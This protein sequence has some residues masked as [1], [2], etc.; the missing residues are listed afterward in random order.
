LSDRRSGSI[1]TV[2]FGNVT[3]RGVLIDLVDGVYRLV[4]RAETRSTSGMPLNDARIAVRR[5]AEEITQVTGRTLLSSDGTVISPERADRNGVDIFITTASTGRT[6]RTLMVGLVPEVSLSSARRAASGTYIEVVDTLSLEDQRSDEDR[7]NAIIRSQADLIFIAGGMEGGAQEPVLKVAQIVTLALRLMQRKP[8]VLYAGNSQ[9]SARI[10]ELFDGVA[11]LFFASNVRPALDLEEL[12]SAQVQLALAFNEQQTKRGGFG[13]LSRMSNLGV[14]PT[15]QSYNVVADYLGRSLGG[16][17]VAVDVGSAVSILATAVNG[18][19]NTS[20]RTDIGLGHSADTALQVVGESAIERWLPF[21]AKPNQIKN[22]V[23]N[24]TLQP[25]SVPETVTALFLEYGLLRAS[26][27]EMLRQAQVGWSKASNPNET[28][29]PPTALVIGAGAAFTRSGNPGL[30]ALLLLDSIQPTGVTQ[31]QLDPYGLIAGLGALA[32]IS[33]EAVVQ[34]LD[35]GSLER[36]GTAI[37]ISGQPRPG[38]SAMRIKMI[39]SDGEVVRQFVQG[40]QIWVYPLA[41]GKT[42]TVEVSAGRGLNIGGKRSV[43]VKLEGGSAGI[44]FDGRGRQLPLALDARGRAAQLP[45]WMAQITGDAQVLLKDEPV[46][47]AE[48]QAAAGKPRRK[49]LFGGGK[50]KPAAKPDAKSQ[51]ANQDDDPFAELDLENELDELRK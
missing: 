1:F 8:T 38:R 13:A 11:T 50:P 22:Y 51:Q 21:T 36:L 18:R 3:T 10:R 44:I 15:A 34:V 4:A 31:L 2:D 39:T 5:L 45:Q 49:G 30:N 29:L 37:S 16:N 24:K 41:T 28:L 23:L 14:L 9:L 48:P 33:Q 19:V 40:G 27:G 17:V 43:K 46:A 25:A 20:I 47:E 35:S 12:E 42:A 26:V 6:L 32:I 7:L